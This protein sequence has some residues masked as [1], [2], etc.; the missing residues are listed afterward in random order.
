MSQVATIKKIELREE[1]VRVEAEF[2]ERGSILAGTKDGSCRGFQ[3]E[4]VL[5]GESDAEDVKELVRLAHRMCFTEDAL[6]HEVPLTVS[7]VFNGKPL[8]LDAG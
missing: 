6:T 1:R 4:L 3:I 5:A 8:P 7:H 2:L